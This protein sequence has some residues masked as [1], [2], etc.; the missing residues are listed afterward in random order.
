MS[1]KPKE[2][3]KYFTLN[4]ILGKFNIIHCEC[5]DDSIDKIR[6]KSGLIFRTKKEAEAKEKEI[7]TILKKR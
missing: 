6:L 7:R 5:Y 2:G 4:L 1:Y 3:E